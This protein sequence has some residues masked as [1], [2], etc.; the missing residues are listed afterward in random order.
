MRKVLLGFVCGV[1]VLG[2]SVFL[3]TVAG[4][5]FLGAVLPD[6]GLTI[7]DVIAFGVDTMS[8]AIPLLAVI[9]LLCTLAIAGGR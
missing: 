9:S 6:V 2:I 1:S 7:S 8:D 3:A 4:A 5:G